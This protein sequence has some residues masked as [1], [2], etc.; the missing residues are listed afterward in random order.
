MNKITKFKESVMNLSPTQQLQVQKVGY[1]GNMVGILFA[2][3]M[4]IYQGMWYFFIVLIF[5]ILLLLVG[6]IEVKQKYDALLEFDT[7]FTDEELNKQINA[8]KESDKNV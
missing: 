5:S 7:Q 3:I 8:I 4:M 2:G 1:I 6:Y